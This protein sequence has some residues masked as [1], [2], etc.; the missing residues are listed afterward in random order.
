MITVLK[1]CVQTIKSGI[2][3]HFYR[4]IYIY[5]TGIKGT[6]SYANEPNVHIFNSNTLAFQNI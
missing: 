3:K 5:K 4:S 2:Q 6:L 1:F